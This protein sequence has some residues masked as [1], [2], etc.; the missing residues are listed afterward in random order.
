MKK[1]NL[2]VNLTTFRVWCYACERE[3]FLEQRLA[4]HLP[5]SSA[6]L[7]EQVY[8]AQ[9][10]CWPQMGQ[11]DPRQGVQRKYVARSSCQKA[12]TE[13]SCVSPCRALGIWLS[14][15]REDWVGARVHSWLWGGLRS[16][17]VPG[18]PPSKVYPKESLQHVPLWKPLGEHSLCSSRAL[19]SPQDGSP[20]L[21][22]GQQTHLLGWVSNPGRP[23]CCVCGCGRTHVVYRCV[24][25]WRTFGCGGVHVALTSAG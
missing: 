11:C 2:T 23:G 17:V 8:S 7:S 15:S 9:A 6:R 10:A 4:V 3:V 19:G 20:D 24:G 25:R 12:L 1:H 16:Q 13:L 22:R 5:S 21:D 18:S 14:R